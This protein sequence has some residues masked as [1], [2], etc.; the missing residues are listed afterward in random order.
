M[1]EAWET[2][3]AGNGEDAAARFDA[4]RDLARAWGFRHL[5]AGG[6]VMLPA[7]VVLERVEATPTP[8]NRAGRG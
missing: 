7:A 3:L 2:R 1:I 4:A 8:A 6:V 5:D